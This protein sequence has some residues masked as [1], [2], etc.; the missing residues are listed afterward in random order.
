MRVNQNRST[1][2][3]LLTN[4]SVSH[5]FLQAPMTKYTCNMNIEGG[6]DILVGDFGDY[7]MDECFDGPRKTVQQSLLKNWEA[8]VC[9]EETLV[10]FVWCSFAFPAIE[11]DESDF[12]LKAFKQEYQSE[13]DCRYGY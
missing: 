11:D 2:S 4:T 12:D 5:V 8:Q 10:T 6:S 13:F 3:N 9:A 1:T 7:D